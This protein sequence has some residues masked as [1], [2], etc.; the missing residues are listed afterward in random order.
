MIWNQLEY[1]VPYC[2]YNRIYNKIKHKICHFQLA[3][4]SEYPVDVYKGHQAGG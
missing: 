3:E 2:A 4:V 1:K